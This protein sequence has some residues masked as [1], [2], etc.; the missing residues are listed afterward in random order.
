MTNV[1]NASVNHFELHGLC[2]ASEKAYGACVYLRHIVSSKQISFKLVCA[3]SRVA[4]LK[5]VTLPRLELAEPN[6]AQLMQKVISSLSIEADNIFW[7]SDSTIVLA[8]LSSSPNNWNTCVANHVAEIQSLSNINNW[9][10]VRSADNPADIISR[11]LS[12]SKLIKSTLWW[13]GPAWLAINPLKLNQLQIKPHCAIP[14]QRT[15]KLT[16]VTKSDPFQFT[17]Y[18]SITRITR[19]FAYIWRFIHNCKKPKF[20]LSDQLKGR[21][22]KN[23]L[24][25]ILKLVQSAS[26][27]DEFNNLKKQ[28]PISTNS[29]IRQLTPFL[30]E[31][32][33]FRVGGR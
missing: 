22:V 6:W 25:R 23:A 17:R 18:S 4:P 3:K 29:H 9:H 24:F 1:Q 13:R 26:F 19:I 20:K 8:W 33:L 30:D 12:S 14:E 5:K 31:N 15:I 10:H 21:E 11:G 16:T 7:W 28:N 27:N 2:D 32:N